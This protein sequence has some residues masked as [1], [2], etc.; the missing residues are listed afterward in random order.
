MHSLLGIPRICASPPDLHPTVDPKG[1]SPSCLQGGTSTH[2]DVACPC[3][4][5][6]INLGD[7]HRHP[8]HLHRIF[9]YIYIIYIYILKLHFSL[10]K[11]FNRGPGDGANCQGQGT[12][13]LE[14]LWC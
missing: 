9:L 4:W 13:T 8:P 5:A 14:S 11:Q 10:Q 2:G 12:S 7:G 1:H 6:G 3:V